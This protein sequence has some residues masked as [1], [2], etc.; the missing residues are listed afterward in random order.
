MTWRGFIAG[1][2]GITNPYIK[3]R[4]YKTRSNSRRRAEV[5]NWDNLPVINGFPLDS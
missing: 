1:S 4:T 2:F 5:E 3:C